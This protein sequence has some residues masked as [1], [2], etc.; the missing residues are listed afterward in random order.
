MYRKTRRHPPHAE[1]VKKNSYLHS[2][3]LI[4]T[5][6]AKLCCEESFLLICWINDDKN[7]L[8][9][10][11]C[12]CVKSKTILKLAWLP[13]WNIMIVLKETLILKAPFQE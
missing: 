9:C 12:V 7:G 6:A 3:Q 13:R 11:C 4:E 1:T 2:G 5:A 10:E 8:E